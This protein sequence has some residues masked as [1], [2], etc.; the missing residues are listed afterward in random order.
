MKHLT[1]SIFKPLNLEISELQAEP[2]SKEYFAHT[3]KLGNKK[4]IFRNAKITPTK[5]GLF[6]SIWKRNDQGITCPYDFKDSFD[7]FLITAQNQNQFGVFIFS[8]KILLEHGILS[9]Q[10]MGGK[11]GVRVYA[12]WD[13]T[14]N[15]Q[16][17][18]TQAWQNKCFID[19]SEQDNADIE[20]VYSLLK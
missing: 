13:L 15:R 16:A 7:L 19:L 9:N 1:T 14:S 18:T 4:I 10:N 6:V 2:E 5:V 12:P 17:Q 20:K 11:R 8:K 3:F